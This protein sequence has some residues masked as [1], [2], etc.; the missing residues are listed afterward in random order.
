MTINNIAQK[1]YRTDSK[2][3]P[4][5]AIPRHKYNFT[6][7]LHRTEGNSVIFHRVSSVTLPNYTF[8]NQVFNQYN[9]RRTIQ[10]RLIYGNLSVA[11]F[12]TY[13]NAWQDI[14]NEYIK[15]NY[16]G[17][18]GLD[19][20]VD[21]SNNDDIVADQ[22]ITSLGFTPNQKRHFFSK[23]SVIQNGYKTGYRETILNFPVITEI[24][25]DTL[26][27]ADSSPVN[28]TVTFQP[29]FIQIHDHN[30]RYDDGV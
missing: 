8:E 15:H 1:I 6:L 2:N 25:S 30:G 20:I 14:M 11:F 28:Y 5:H 24:Q 29:E 9:R 10:T 13:D 27:Y 17:T 26:T 18:N 21:K 7:V 12:D 22:F 3:D 4:S 16:N 19:Q 23:V